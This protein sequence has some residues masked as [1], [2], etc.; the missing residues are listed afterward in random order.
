[1]ASTIKVDTIDTPS[2]AGSIT[3][4]QKIAGD[5]NALVGISPR[6]YIIDGDFTQWP[7]GTSATTIAT[8]YTSAM[9]NVVTSHDGTATWERSTDV[10]TV[11]QSG[12][13]SAYSHLTKCTGADASLGA[14]Q[15]LYYRNYITGNDFAHLHQQTVTLSFWSKT[16]A[17]NSG[18]TYYFFLWNSATNRAYVQNFAPTSSWTKFEYTI[19]LDTVW[20]IYIY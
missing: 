15:F 9:M 11:A 1:M 10:P 6:N 14:S 18:D 20:Y 7:E 3:F 2:G 17:A 5:G 4:S 13:Q 8:G 12:H 19:A 16:A